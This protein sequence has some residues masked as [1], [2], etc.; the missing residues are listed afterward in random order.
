MCCD[1]RTLNKITVKNKYPIPLV[2][3]CFDRLSQANYFTKIDLRLGYWQV[4]IKEGDEAKTTVVTRYGA[5]EFLV[6]PFSLTNAPATFSTM[7]NQNLGEHVEHLWQVLARL[8]EYELYAKVS[9][10]SFAQETISFLGHIVEKGRIWMDPKKVQAIEEWKPPSD[11]HDLRSFLGLANYY[12]RF[13]KS[14]SE[15]ARPMTDLLKKTE[16][17][18]WTPQCQESFDRLK[19]AMVTDPVLALPDM[20][21]PFVVET[22]ASDF[23]LGGIL[24]QDGHPVAFESRKLKEVES[25]YSVHEKEL[26]AVVHCLRLWRHYLLG[27]PF[28]VKTD[29]TAVSHFMTQ[30]KLTSRQARWQELL[31]QFYFVLEY[32]AGSS[33]HVADALSRR[34]DLASPGPPH[35]AGQSSAILAGRR[36]SDDQGKSLVCAKGRG[37]E[38]VTHFGMPRH[39]L[40]GHQGEERTYAL[41][42]R[43]Y[44]WPQMRDDVEMYVRTCLICQQDKADHQKK[45]GSIIVV[46]DRLSKYATF[47]TAPKHV[48]TEGMAH[49]FFKHIVKYWGLS[50][51][52]VSDRDSRFTGV[53]WTELFKI[54]G[55]KLSMSTS[56]HPQFDG[57]TERFNSMLEEYLRHFVR[58]TQK[59]WVK[60]LDVAQL[61][62]NAQKS[63]ST[64]KSAFKIVTGQQPLLPHTLDSPQK[65]DEEVCRSKPPLHQ[66]QCGRPGDGEDP[67]PEIV[68]VI[69]GEGSSIDAEVC[70]SFAHH[71][72]Y[73]TVAY[74]IEL[75]PWWK[76]H[77]V[78]HVS[79]LK[80]YSADREDDARN[81]PSR[82]QLELTKTKEKV[83]EAILNHRVTRTAKREHT[84]YLVKWKG[85][86]SEENTWERVTK[87]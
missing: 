86:S 64:N 11:V 77:N 45:A 51:D 6:M 46:V 35:R 59:D 75:P 33:N 66:V 53:F 84:E 13:V 87:P 3:D 56:Y 9:K 27:S 82:P 22:D 19:R 30:S 57:Q 79:Q 81:Q 12:R 21:K 65:A 38:E 49:L 43:A 24:M 41:V 31:S 85:C 5:F 32:R 68:E 73:W 58:G 7:M 70:R 69:K 83:A 80:K 74:R 61:C 28:V 48:T 72:A 55:S 78:F 10:C 39:S 15:I 62:F 26:L 16:T 17:W 18:N 37:P 1:Y 25:R 42:Q 60:L 8:H 34:A 23:A 2:A 54:L 63:S 36:P 47:I 71:E 52:I 4:R 40:G 14:Y 20:S 44:F 67:G 76:I 50:K 29:N